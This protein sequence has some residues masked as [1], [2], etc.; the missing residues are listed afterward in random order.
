MK[1]VDDCK[2]S[3]IDWSTDQHLSNGGERMGGREGVVEGKRPTKRIEGEREGSQG[4]RGRQQDEEKK[5]R[6]KRHLTF[7]PCCCPL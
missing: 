7:S 3:I 6:G 4:N 5:G 1:L 2:I